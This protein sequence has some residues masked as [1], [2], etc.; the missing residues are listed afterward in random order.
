MK[1]CIIWKITTN[2]SLFIFLFF[3]PVCLNA[4]WGMTK[5]QFTFF[6]PPST[7][8]SRK[9]EWI[10]KF[11][12]CIPYCL[13]HLAGT[14]VSAGSILASPAGSFHGV[15]DGPL[16]TPISSPIT[17][18]STPSPDFVERTE[19]YENDPEGFKN[20]IKSK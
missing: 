12:Y 13:L 6:G 10:S 9:I 18:P 5:T 4:S 3:N 8:I 17:P 7:R 20:E 11:M 14:E 1:P 16:V 19:Y 2:A 15:D